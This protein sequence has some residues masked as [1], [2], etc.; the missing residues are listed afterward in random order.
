[1]QNVTK[2][3]CLPLALLTIVGTLGSG[4]S[5]GH[6]KQPD[7]GVT[8]DLAM[9]AH[10]G[11]APADGSATADGGAPDASASP[12]LGMAPDDASPPS[13]DGDT[14]ACTSP[15]TVPLDPNAQT[16]ATAVLTALSPSATLQWA[17]VRGTI[18]SISGLVVTLPDCQGTTDIFGQL[19]DVLDQSPDL[20]QI[21]RTEW[22]ASGTLQCADVLASG[23]NT[24][25]IR[26]D[27]YG[28]YS[29]TNDVF[30]AVADVQNGVVILRNFSGTYIPRPTADFITTLQ[31]CPDK[32]NGAVEPL[33][34]AAPF[35]YEKFA[36]APA[37]A[38]TLDGQDSYS[39]MANDTMTFDPSVM[40]LW[41]DST[42][43]QIRRQRAATLVVA[44]ANYT[45]TLENSDAN[46]AD[47]SNTPN[48][49]W[50][51]TFDSV[52]GEVLYDKDNPDPTCTVC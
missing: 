52:T 38:C 33:L 14:A 29:L 42:T 22:H 46:C 44:P 8:A 21:D 30:S 20:F 5:N 27:K 6:G 4:C 17:P 36:P 35:M 37:P 24:L 32:S 2:Q 18:S 23:F 47:E 11:S 34:R 26:R 15:F 7:A 45:P 12:D 3:R 40:L 25:V 10:D 50:I 1:M 49:G 41:D 16:K 19:F 39:A 48:I 31:A 9:P 43:L 28:P 51:R 13:S